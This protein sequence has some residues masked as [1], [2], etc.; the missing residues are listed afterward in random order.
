MNRKEASGIHLKNITHPE[1]P[2]RDNQYCESPSHFLFFRF[3]TSSS[4]QLATG[5][6]VETAGPPLGLPGAEK[7]PLAGT[8]PTSHQLLKSKA[9]PWPITAQQKAANTAPIRPST[10]PLTA[11]PCGR[12][13]K[14]NGDGR[15]GAVEGRGPGQWRHRAAP[16]GCM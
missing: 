6:Q 14:R 13:R 10:S 9:S 7:F 8:D 11:P 16:A 4:P 2:S 5:K 1:F 15:G 12:P 3:A